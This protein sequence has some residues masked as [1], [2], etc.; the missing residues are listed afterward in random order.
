MSPPDKNGEN[1][2]K[3]EKENT[4]NETEGIIFP[5]APQPSFEN[6]EQIGISSTPA[7][8]C[9]DDVSFHFFILLFTSAII[10]RNKSHISIFTIC[11]IMI[12]DGSMPVSYTHLTLPT[13]L[14]V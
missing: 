3:R 14:L 1:E 2:S 6:S 10:K 4:S 9:V 11:N 5:I 12:K 8:Q 13:I 7:F